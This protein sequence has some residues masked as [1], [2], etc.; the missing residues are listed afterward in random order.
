[1]A[2]ELPDAGLQ[3]PFVPCWGFGDPRG[4]FHFHSEDTQPDSVEMN[5]ADTK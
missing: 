5:S 4:G 3:S 2:G 1:M